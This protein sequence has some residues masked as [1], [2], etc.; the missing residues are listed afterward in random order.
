MDLTGIFKNK[1]QINGKDWVRRL[2][3]EDLQ[4]F[5][6]IGLKATDFGRLGG[7]ANAETCKRDKHGKFTR[8]DS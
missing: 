4:V 1:Y 6:D 7:I 3:P 8:K 5:I 2:E